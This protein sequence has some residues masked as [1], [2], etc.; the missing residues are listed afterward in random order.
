MKTFK[1]KTGKEIE[2]DKECFVRRSAISFENSCVEKMELRKETLHFDIENLIHSFAGE[3]SF[4]IEFM[5]DE[6][7][8][9]ISYHFY[10]EIEQS[11][12]TLVP[13]VEE[14]LDTKKAQIEVVDIKL[15]PEDIGVFCADMFWLIKDN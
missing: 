2:T 7:R 5:F 12:I 14:K 13:Y 3:N 10:C 8:F 6:V 4:S 11:S 1:T 15:R 9:Y